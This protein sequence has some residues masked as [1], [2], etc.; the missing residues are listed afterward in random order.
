MKRILKRVSEWGLWALVVVIFLA[1]SGAQAAV[2]VIVGG[3]LLGATGVNV[4]GTVYDVQFV[5]G[6][7]VDLYGGCD[8]LSDFTFTNLA[9]ALLAG[10]ARLGKGQVRKRID[11]LGPLWVL[12]V[13][14]ST[15]SSPP[16]DGGGLRSIFVT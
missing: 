8:D 3:E 4:G 6:T 10:Q 16:W 7:C 5:E 1:T 2:P 11:W 12:R 15:V 13:G 9:D 14:C